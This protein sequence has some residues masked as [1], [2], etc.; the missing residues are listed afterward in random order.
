MKG[1]D[2][3]DTHE[4]YI[5]PTTIPHSI[6]NLLFNTSDTRYKK[7]MVNVLKSFGGNAS[8]IEADVLKILEMEKQLVKI[9]LPSNLSAEDFKDDNGEFRQMNIRELA[10]SVPAVPWKK[11]IEAT[12]DHNPSVEIS[13]TTRVNV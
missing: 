12:L 2:A 8:T 1:L 10:E 11:Y 3:E 5:V 6:H 7:L 4:I 13:P 9:G